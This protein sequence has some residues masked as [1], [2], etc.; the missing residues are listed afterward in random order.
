MTEQPRGAP[1]AA[2][3]GAD[4]TVL[5]VRNLRRSYPGVLAVDDMSMELRPGQ[6][7]GLVGPNGAGKSTV[8][9]MLA[10]AVKPER[11][12]ILI[13]GEPVEIS[14]P[15]HATQ[16]GLSFVHQELTDVPNLSVAENVLLGLR[17]PHRGPILDRRRLIARSKDVLTT[18]LQVDI[19]PR[20]EQ[21][22]LSVA[23]R[24]L[25]MI[26]RGLAT[27]ARVLTLDEPSASLTNQEITHLHEVIRRVVG[28]GA[29]VIYVS[30]RLDEIFSLTDRVVVMRGGLKVADA[31]TSSPQPPAARRPHHRA[32]RRD[33]RAPAR[34]GRRSDRQAPWRAGRRPAQRAGTE[35]RRGRTGRQLRRARVGDPR[36]RR[37]GWL[38]AHRADAD[39]LRRRSARQWRDPRRRQAGEHSQPA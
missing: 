28:Q 19:D 17:Y 3:D 37:S 5:E 29:A 1:A 9:K 36:H 12:E 20:A 21:G 2:R 4:T 13:D 34:R 31:P 7:L 33:P 22:G 8:I 38:R 16:L 18:G 24:R 23:Q 25:V 35:P 30:H 6:I 10:G 11:G 14:S 39:G 15:H 27:R 32:G 26:A